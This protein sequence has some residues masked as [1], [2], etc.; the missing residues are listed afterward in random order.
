[1]SFRDS[2][3]IAFAPHEDDSKPTY[4]RLVTSANGE[5]Q[6]QDGSNKFDGLVYAPSQSS[7]LAAKDEDFLDRLPSQIFDHSTG[8][9]TSHF[10]LLDFG[11][12][13]FVN[14]GETELFDSDL[15][16]DSP[17]R[18]NLT[19]SQNVQECQTQEHS[20]SF[21]FHTARRFEATGNL[22]FSAQY[23]HD[24]F[25]ELVDIE[26]SLT[27]PIPLESISTYVPQTTGHPPDA[28]RPNLSFGLLESEFQGTEN[29]GLG[30]ICPT[31]KL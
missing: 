22:E 3:D 20:N 14:Q 29:G 6:I 31:V 26:M 21:S 12:T 18:H 27:D 30:L 28:P 25:A 23:F 9:Y 7:F 8:A 1:M 15:V 4:A 11:F 16:I 13:D 17:L 2:E 19:P 5:L 10:G 24:P